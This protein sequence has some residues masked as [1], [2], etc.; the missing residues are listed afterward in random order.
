VIDGVTSNSSRGSAQFAASEAGTL[1]YLPGQ[2]LFDARPIAWMD[3]QGIMTSLRDVPAHWSDAEFSPDG[4]RIA[5][6][7]RRDGQTDIFVYGLA[8][9]TLTPVALGSG[10]EE[11]PVWTRDGKHI[12]YRSFTPS[13]NPPYTLSLK[14]A[15][16]TGDALIL[17]QSTGPLR[18]ESWHPTQNVLAFVAERPGTGAD[19]MLLP[20]EG[21]ETSGW[22]PGQ[23]TAFLESAS[24]ERNPAFSHDGKWLAYDSN[25]SGREAVGSHDVYVRP[26]PG[27]GERVM[28]SSAAGASPSWSRSTGELVFKV[29]LG[30]G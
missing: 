6:D 12:V 25:E 8:R 1:A 10:D 28:V 14:R 29:S 20:L 15:D 30:D 24:R 7:I 18:P 17:T 23:P 9:G 3:R 5:M 27:P 22:R 4:D 11:Y 26:F 2:N 19:V 13:S 21:D 16:G